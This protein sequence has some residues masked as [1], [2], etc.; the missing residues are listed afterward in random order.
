MTK[1]QL[2][3]DFK[4]WMD[5]NEGVTGS[6]LALEDAW[7]A[8]AKKYSKSEEPNK[9][10]RE[11]LE[12]IPDDEMWR[13]EDLDDGDVYY[14]WGSP[15]EPNKGFDVAMNEYYKDITFG[16]TN[17]ESIS[18]RPATKQERIEVYKKERRMMPLHDFSDAWIEI[19]RAHV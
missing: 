12:N 19:G 13:Y 11:Q 16:T 9:P 3:K 14:V 1:E 4:E 6:W 17:M 10:S 2:I 15:F 5:K 18:A 7:M 8:A